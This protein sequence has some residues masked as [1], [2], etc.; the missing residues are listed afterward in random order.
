[1]KVTKEFLAIVVPLVATLLTV[2][3][4][5]KKEN[6]EDRFTIDQ[7]KDKW[8][9]KIEAEN[10]ELLKEMKELRNE[11]RELIIENTNLHK[12]LSVIKQEVYELHKRK[13]EK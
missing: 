2:Y 7:N 12:E 5:I 1:V 3:Q 9:E 13:G 4:G 10:D 8:I 11:R 6:R